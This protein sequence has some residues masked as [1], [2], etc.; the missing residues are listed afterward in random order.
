[1]KLNDNHSSEISNLI[2]ENKNE[3]EQIKATIKLEES[4]RIGRFEDLISRQSQEIT[5]YKASL[6]N[7]KKENSYLNFKISEIETKLKNADSDL[8]RLKYIFYKK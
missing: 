4:S 7:L 2:E 5:E 6:A 3:I 8:Q 1:M